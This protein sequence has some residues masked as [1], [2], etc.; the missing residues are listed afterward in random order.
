MTLDEF[1]GAHPKVA[2]GF[3]GG[4]DSSYLL[5]AAMR[6]G[7]DV[8]AYFAKTQFQPEFELEDALKLGKQL[9]AKLTVLH[10]DVLPAA[11]SNPPNRC[12]YCK[13]ALFGALVEAFCS[14]ENARMLAMKSATDSAA[15]MLRELSVIYNSVR[16]AAITQQI[17]EVA[18]GAKAQKRKKTS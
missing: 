12:Y 18:G 9:G 17:V 14:E 3:S 2:L 15:D 13:T 16:Q 7:A 5:Y 10:Y 8:Q 6:A 11:G 4:V 1:F